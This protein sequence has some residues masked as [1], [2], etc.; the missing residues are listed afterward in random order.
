MYSIELKPRAQ[1]FIEDQTKKIQA[2]ITKRIEILCNNP[3]PQNSRQLHATQKLYRLA[4]GDYRIVYQVDDEKSL[5]MIATIGN[6]KDVYRQ[7]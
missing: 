1:R 6:R 2:Q 3:H 5:I 7:I 4:C